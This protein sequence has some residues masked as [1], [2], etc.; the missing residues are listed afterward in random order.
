MDLKK[1]PNSNF[2]LESLDSRVAASKI[3]EQNFSKL[4]SAHKKADRT[5]TMAPPNSTTTPTNQ[6]ISQKAKKASDAVYVDDKRD[7]QPSLIHSTIPS[8][9]PT[10]AGLYAPAKKPAASNPFKHH[11]ANF[12]P[13]VSLSMKS[14][15]TPIDADNF[16]E[17]LREYRRID[18]LNS[19]LSTKLTN[20]FDP[21]FPQVAPDDAQINN[22]TQ[23][24]TFAMMPSALDTETSPTKASK[25]HLQG[26]SNIH[27]D[28]IAVDAD[29]KSKKQRF[30]FTNDDENT[31]NPPSTLPDSMSLQTVEALN[32][33]EPHIYK[34]YSNRTPVLQPFQWAKIDP[35]PTG[36]SE[37]IDTLVP[38]DTE[39]VTIENSG[40]DESSERHPV[41]THSPISISTI[42]RCLYKTHFQN[43]TENDIPFYCHHIHG[44]NS[45]TVWHLNP[46]P[47]KSYPPRTP[48]YTDHNTL[49]TSQS[50]AKA[51]IP[52][53]PNGNDN[54]PYVDTEMSFFEFLKS[55]LKPPTSPKHHDTSPY[56]TL[57]SADLSI[58]HTTP[59]QTHPR[60]NPADKLQAQTH[61]L[62]PSTNND[63]THPTTV[64]KLQPHAQTLRDSTNN[65]TA[66]P[67]VEKLQLHAQP[68]CTS[69]RNGTAHPKPYPVEK[70]N[71]RHRHYTSPSLRV[72][73]GTQNLLTSKNYKNFL[74]KN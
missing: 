61:S 42:G 17:L 14:K 72:H 43:G 3:F 23:P 11:P 22:S 7:I 39:V 41:K 70:Y 18:A 50:D 45:D 67:T 54:F 21:S 9:I 55:I 6:A 20:N 37:V 44:A 40:R 47:P 16:D 53:A 32:E 46:T 34:T 19:P 8:T 56:V 59:S 73:T 66:H 48:M 71:H 10:Y 51:S 52:I 29:R 24:S 15:K 74:L 28:P 1:A 57:A 33:I 49:L 12:S 63:T 31:K 13:I 35:N 27:S 69:S 38:A 26:P 5:S 60:Q 25:R 65:D 36:E 30:A 62:C 2:N 4:N 68:P 64:E 58:S